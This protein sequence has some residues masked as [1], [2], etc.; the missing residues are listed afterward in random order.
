MMN[1]LY[2]RT[3]FPL[4]LCLVLAFPV[5]MAVVEYAPPLSERTTCCLFRLVSGLDCPVC[6]LTR[7]FR[8]MGRLDVRLAVVYNPLGPAVFLATVCYWAY[9]AGMLLTGGRLRVPAWWRRQQRRAAWLALAIFLASCLARI[10]Y[11]LRHP[12]PPPR[13]PIGRLMRISGSLRAPR[14]I[15]EVDNNHDQSAY[16][17]TVSRPGIPG[18]G[19]GPGIDG[20]S[21]PRAQDPRRGG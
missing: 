1:A 12:P 8:A 19:H 2:R 21:A 6:G 10:G 20:A 13:W 14:P 15:D 11:E 17:R 9:A 5:G 16:R 18:C 4:H 7:A 3:L